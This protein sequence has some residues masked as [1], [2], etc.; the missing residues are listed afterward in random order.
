MVDATAE[1]ELLNFMEAYS[2]YNQIPMHEPD[3]EHTSFIIDHCLHCYTVM[4]L[5][6]MNVEATYQR[7]VNSMFNQ[8]IGK[9]MEIYVNDILVKSTE[10]KDH[11]QHL[12]VMFK[13][14]RKY[15]MKLNPRKCAFGVSS[16]KFL[17]Y[18]VNYRGIEAN[19]EKNTGRY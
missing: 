15:K 13:I 8:Q 16:G 11:C 17:G 19:P 12:A 6:L 14:L 7:L 18:M 1:H 5:G 4:P 10:A 3:Q 2:G 9:T